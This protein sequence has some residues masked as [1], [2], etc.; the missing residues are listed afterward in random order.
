MKC[1]SCWLLGPISV[2][3]IV[4]TRPSMFTGPAYTGAPAASRS[5]VSDSR[6]AS[7][8]HRPNVYESCSESLKSCANLSLA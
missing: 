6:S 1:V 5:Q 8:R 7:F 4:N 3:P 2:A